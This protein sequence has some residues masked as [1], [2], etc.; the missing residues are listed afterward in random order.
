MNFRT[1]L[2][3][4]RLIAFIEGWS[5]LILIGV[6]M[7]LKYA[8]NIPEPNAAI[9][10]LHG[11]LFVLYCLSAIEVLVRR[12]WNGIG[13]AFL[14]WLACAVASLVPLGTFALDVWLRRMQAEDG[15]RTLGAL[16]PSVE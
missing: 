1:P 13:R 4:L 9:G 10:S 6:G 11:F 14:F 5:F 8:A 7:P 3:R 12:T 15:Q 2:G 16:P